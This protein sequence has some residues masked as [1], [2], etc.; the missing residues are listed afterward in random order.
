MKINKLL[1]SG[2]I[3]LVFI[4]ISLAEIISKIEFVGCQRVEPETIES[5]LPIQAGEEYTQDAVNE[6]LKSLNATEFFEEVNIDIKGSTLIVKV[7]EYPI[8]NKISFEGNSKLSDRDINNAVRLKP[9][10]V[11]SPSKV[12]EIQQGMLE[13]YRK[14]GRYNASVT[15]KVIKLDNNRVNLVF[16]IN[17]GVAAGIGRIIFIGNNNYSANELRDVIYSKVKRWYRFFVTDDIYDSERLIEDKIALTKFYNENGYANAK[18]T[19]ATAELSSDKKEFNLTFVIDEGDVYKVGDVKVK[20]HI[21]KLPDKELMD[22][23]YCKK[24][25]KFNSSLLEVDA[26]LVAKKAGLKGFSAIRVE[27]DVQQDQKT[28][29]INIT[30]SVTEGSKIYISKIMIKGNSRTRDRVIRR[31]ILL[32]EGDSYNQALA[33]LSELKI[34]QLGFFKNVSVDMIPDLHSPDKCIIEVTVEETSTGEAMVAGSF[35]TGDGLGVDLTYNERNFLGTGKSL[36]VYLGSGKSRTGRSYKINEDGKAEKVHRKEKFKFFNNVSVTVSDPR[37]FDKDIEGSLS[38]F[39]YQTGKWDTFSAKELGGAIGVSYELSSKFSQSWEYTGINRKFADVADGASPFIKYQTMKKEGDTISLAK[40]GKNNLSSIK[41][42]ISYGTQFLTGM[43]GSFKTGLSTTAAGIGGDA[44]HLKNEVWGSYLIPVSR[45]T[46]L[47]LSLSTGLLSNIGGKSPHVVDSYSKGLDS[48]RGFDD[49]GVGPFY[50]TKRI[51][52]ID[53]PLTGEKKVMPYTYRDYAGA[54]KYWKGTVELTFPIGLPEE[55]QFRGFVF[56]DIGTLWDPPEKGK[57]FMK[58]Y[59]IGSSEGDAAI[60]ERKI[61][62][63]IL[64]KGFGVE[65]I[66]DIKNE[67][68]DVCDFDKTVFKHKILDSK[69][70]RASIGL[71]VSFV[72]PF[73]PMRFTY[74][75]PIRKEKYDEP[76]RFLIGFSTTF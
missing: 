18:V 70:M 55:L 68:I 12:K 41:H 74:A 43:K 46:S 37:I 48:F 35:S 63:K 4:N 8:I 19:S 22:D 33:N 51:A 20:S 7:K 47:T 76:Y 50:E 52:V 53:N 72:T 60:K 28:K 30:F 67:T 14:M 54:K 66:N 40:P 23:F 16:E 38:A 27:P 34:R 62:E 59:K 9:R 75:F 11:L 39:R 17:E 65:N 15:P 44:R 45:K 2:V 73:G 21:A 58:S 31:E 10:E 3:A 29:T 69:K 6:A 64:L 1:L 61:Q 36:S 24:G 42:T 57:K 56:S 71:G 5:Y 25:D 13:A 32:E 26:G 49:C